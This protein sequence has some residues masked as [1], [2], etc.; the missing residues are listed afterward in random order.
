M[1][2]E[3]GS[4]AVIVVIVVIGARFLMIDR[5]HKKDI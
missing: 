2:G 5:T 1:M 3:L 4:L